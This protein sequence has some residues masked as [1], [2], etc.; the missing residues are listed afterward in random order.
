MWEESPHTALST[1]ENKCQDAEEQKELPTQRRLSEK[2]PLSQVLEGGRT[3]RACVRAH[4]SVRNRAH[5]TQ[6]N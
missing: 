2:A 1:R 3:A 5:F 4:K 6:Q